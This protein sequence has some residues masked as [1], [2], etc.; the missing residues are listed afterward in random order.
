VGYSR[1]EGIS[2]A[3]RTLAPA[4]IVCDEIGGE[5]DARAIEEAGLCGVPL[6]ASVHGGAVE[7]VV[8][9]PHL[10]RLLRRG[11]FG[12]LVGICR[13]EKEFVSETVTWEEARGI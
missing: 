10:R 9:L 13:R 5:E 12:Y 2:I 1:G 11:L 8:R 4:L 3:L 7:E 6:I